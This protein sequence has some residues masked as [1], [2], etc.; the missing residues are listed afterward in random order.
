MTI[1]VTLAISRV[2]LPD[3][4]TPVVVLRAL[5]AL[6]GRLATWTPELNGAPAKARFV[7]ATVAA[8][9][10]FVVAATAL[11]GI[12]VVVPELPF[13]ADSARIA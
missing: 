5:A 11:T 4:Q 10:E 12:S 7:F 1:D 6:G 3:G 2:D 8:R 13:A 9:D